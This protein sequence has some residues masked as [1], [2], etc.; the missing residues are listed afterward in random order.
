M[1][2]IDAPGRIAR[3]RDL[4][5]AVT[6]GTLSGL[7]LLDA[8][9][10]ATAALVDGAH[11][12]KLIQQAHPSAP[13]RAAAR[14]AAGELH[15]ATLTIS[16][17]PAVY[18]A[19]D[20]VSVDDP[21]DR[22]YLDRVRRDLRRN[23]LDAP[24]E[25]RSRVRELQLR[26]HGI[27]Q[28]FEDAI[29]SDE[30]SA[31]FPPSALAGMPPSYLA[32]HPPGPD[33]LIILTT[34]HPDYLPILR[35]CP[36][37]GVRETMW[38][39]FQER[40]RPANIPILDELRTTRHEL[41]RLLGF[42]SFADYAAADKMIGTGPAIAAFLDDITDASAAATA[43]DYERLLA[44]SPDPAPWDIPYLIEQVRTAD[45]GSDTREL[46]PYFEFGRVKAG[47]VTLLAGLFDVHF[48]RVSPGGEAWHPEVETYD[49]S[50]ASG[51]L[52][53]RVHLD[54]HP[55]AGKYGHAALFAMDGGK[56]GERLPSCALVANFP[57]PGELMMPG[58]VRT[59]LHE[60][61]HVIH[62]VLAG[63]GR[64]SGLT[65]LSVEWDFV[66]T[67]SQLLEEWLADPPTLAAFAV[68]H[69]TGEPL[70]AAAVERLEAAEAFGRGLE[71][72]RQIFLAALSL[73]L[74]TDPGRPPD[75]VAA[76][77]HRRLLPH[78]H[79]GEVWQHLS[80]LHLAWYSACYYT[81]QWSLVIAKDLFTAFAAEGLDNPAV[82]HRYRDRVLARGSSAPAATL[83][84]EFLGRPQNSAAYRAWL[85]PPGS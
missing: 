55:R 22:H 61:G 82:A 72:R 81:Y 39:L 58:E 76:V 44:V 36:D 4:I 34:A 64:W 2:A 26:L 24:D 59:F 69:E 47:I 9:D 80:F 65:G 42:P 63:R 54:L 70:P 15:A 45:Y 52:L 74:H 41:A 84:A 57:R 10:E 23:G 49:V 8:Y 30:R 5:T 1:H 19:L 33:G 27:E 12:A 40:G 3:A 18:R 28:D 31:A 14:Q 60:F 7:D 66:E 51:E 67:P 71:T 32:A 68:H 62:Y 11:H 85:A 73:G 75:D 38:R 17:D 50:S 6:S 35:Y 46:L 48:T 78:R 21:V 77:A 20:G 83:V 16:L 37:A 25:V 79:A 43:S 56:A 53:G 29:R 13:A